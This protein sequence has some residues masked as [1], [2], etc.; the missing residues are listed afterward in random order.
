MIIG[1]LVRWKHLDDKGKPVV[2]LEGYVV[3]F[4]RASSSAWSALVLQRDGTFQT[5]NAADL[6]VLEMARSGPLEIEPPKLTLE[7]L[8]EI[9]PPID[10]VEPEDDESLQALENFETYL[11]GKFPGLESY[12]GGPIDRARAMLDSVANLIDCL[13][14]EFP[15][16]DRSE[17][18]QPGDHAARL[19][20]ELK[21]ELIAIAGQR[22]RAEGALKTATD[23]IAKLEKDL[24][25]ARK[26][27]KPKGPA[28]PGE[29]EEPKS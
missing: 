18:E 17:G 2:P 20:R 22:D 25:A 5:A 27:N 12:G 9:G 24:A 28:G 14:T 4:E 21:A 13:G 16:Y 1:A 6:V 8:A 29:T 7:A 26:K 10:P 15:A 19:I 23:T 3:T 11:D